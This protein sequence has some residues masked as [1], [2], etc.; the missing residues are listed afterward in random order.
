MASLIV[1]WT[2]GITCIYFAY[3]LQKKHERVKLLLG[4]SKTLTAIINQYR[5]VVFESTYRAR[6]RCEDEYLREQALF[7]HAALI[8]LMFRLG[9]NDKYIAYLEEHYPDDFSRFQN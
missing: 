2:L 4:T 1:I 7:E 8:E 6:L 5:G 3:L 9:I